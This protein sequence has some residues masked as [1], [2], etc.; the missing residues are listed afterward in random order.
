MISFTF[1]CWFDPKLYR[2]FGRTSCL[3]TSTRINLYSQQIIFVIKCTM[4]K[5][6]KNC[7]SLIIPL[8]KINDICPTSFLFIKSFVYWPCSYI[9]VN[10]NRWIIYP[11][12]K[13]HGANFGPIWGRQDPGG[14]HVGRMNFAIWVVLFRYAQHL[15]QFILIFPVPLFH[16]MSRW[17]GIFC[18]LFCFSFCFVI[19]NCNELLRTFY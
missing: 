11:D 7:L 4:M 19:Y 17:A 12:S 16:C 1:V 6:A 2:S 5:D 14:P 3:Y 10:N 18:D 15:R 13:V 9:T 8:S